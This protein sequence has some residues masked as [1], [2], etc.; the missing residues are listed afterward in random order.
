MSS[1]LRIQK[2]AFNLHFQET[3][4]VSPI[5]YNSYSNV[6]MFFQSPFSGDFLCFSIWKFVEIAKSITFNLHFQETFF[7][8][9]VEKMEELELKENFQSPFS[10]DF[11]CFDSGIFLFTQFTLFTFNLHFQETFF[12]SGGKIAWDVEK[13]KAFNLHFQE[14]FFVSKDIATV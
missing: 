1:F 4:F 10:G 2:C 8:S 12:V 14:T 6:V 11:L 13:L 7:V 3:F 5:V 9:G